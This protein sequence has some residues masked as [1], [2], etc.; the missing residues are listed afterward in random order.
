MEIVIASANAKKVIELSNILSDLGVSIV[1]AKDCGFTEEIEETGT[2]FEEN[3]I[4]KAKAVCKALGKPAIADDSG[5]C[6]DALDG[7]PGVYS[8]RYAKD[9]LSRCNKLICEMSDKDCKTAKFVSSIALVMPNGEMILAQGE[10]YGEIL[11]EM[12]G[13]G[14]FGYDPLFF[15]KEIGKTFAELTNEEKNSISHRGRALTEFYK[16]FKEKN[17]AN[18]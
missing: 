17:Y 8:A 9:D 10:V 12:R 6:V 14:G 2:T 16:Q 13:E 7:R 5:I 15:I 4:I 11:D 3:A 1:T 18:K